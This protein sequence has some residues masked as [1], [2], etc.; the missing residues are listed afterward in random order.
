MKRG[1]AWSEN[2]LSHQKGNQWQSNN[3]IKKQAQKKEEICSRGVSILIPEVSNNQTCYGICRLGFCYEFYV[4]EGCNATKK[5]MG[6]LFYFYGCVGRLDLIVNDNL[7]MKWFPAEFIVALLF[8]KI[9]L[10]RKSLADRNLIQSFT[11]RN[12]VYLFLKTL[13]KIT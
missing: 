1:L 2:P 6:Q 7:T 9:F 8:I 5:L 3:L 10:K 13:L 4:Y 12:F 11:F